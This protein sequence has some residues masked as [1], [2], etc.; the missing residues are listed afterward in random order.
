ML[1]ARRSRLLSLDPRDGGV[2]WD[3]P[4]GGWPRAIVVDGGR[5]W[6]LPPDRD[7]LICLDLATG[8]ER[9]RAAVPPWT[10]HLVVLGDGVLTGGWRGYTALRIFDRSSGVLRWADSR[11]TETVLPAVSGAGLLVGGTGAASVRVISVPGGDEVA[12]WTLPGPLRAGEAGRAAFVP[13]GPDR[14][15]VRCGDRTVFEI[16][17]GSGHGGVLFQ[18]SADLADDGISVA[19]GEVW[20]RESRGAQVAVGPPA[21]RADPAGGCAH[22]V[23][24]VGRGTVVAGRRPG[25]LLLT[26]SDGTVLGR[27]TVDQRIAAVHGLGPDTVLVLGQG[28]ATAVTVD[29]EAQS[30]SSTR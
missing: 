12:G 8:A 1:H 19:G 11:A 22:G 2:R 14:F 15:L 18:H 10:G 24:R 4:I 6:V 28:T 26:G 25:A 20:V 30:P 29:D 17:P 23:V 7:L 16:R 27:A 9:W 13:A 5:C 3:V 21:R